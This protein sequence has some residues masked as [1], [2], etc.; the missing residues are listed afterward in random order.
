MS[1]QNNESYIIFNLCSLQG[2]CIVLD[3]AEDVYDADKENVTD[4]L[5]RLWNS[6]ED[7]RNVITSIFIYFLVKCYKLLF[8]DKCKG[9]ND[10]LYRN[11]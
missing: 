1:L 5:C 11:I 3:N 9:N 6:S 4:I 10:I 7:M 8:I 2:T